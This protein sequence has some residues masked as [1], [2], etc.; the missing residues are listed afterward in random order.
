MG[1]TAWT[2]VPLDKN[3]PGKP[4]RVYGVP[5]RNT[6]NGGRNTG[7]QVPPGTGTQGDP[8]TGGPDGAP[9]SP[10]APP[11]GGRGPGDG[12]GFTNGTPSSQPPWVVQPPLQSGTPTDPP[13][14]VVQPPINSAPTDP[15]PW[16]IQP[17]PIVGGVQSLSATGSPRVTGTKPPT[18]SSP[19]PTTP[20][21]GGFAK[22]TDPMDPY[23]PP[24]E[25]IPETVPVDTPP[26][27]DDGGW[28]ADPSQRPPSAAPIPPSATPPIDPTQ[29]QKMEQVGHDGVWNGMNREQWRDAW[30]SQGTM[31]AQ[32]MDAWMASHGATKMG[33]NGTFLTPFGEVLDLGTGYKTGHPTAGWTPPG[34]GGGGGGTGAGGGDG[35][36]GAGTG[37]TSFQDQIRAMLLDQLKK[38]GQPVDL[39]DP[40]LKAE[41]DTQGNAL[42]Q[43]RRDRRG[44]AAERAAMQGL[45]SGGQSSGA[46]DSEVASGFE[47]KANNQSAVIANMYGREMQAKRTQMQNLLNMAVQSG[48]AESARALQLKIAEMDAELKRMGLAQSQSQWN[49]SFG[50]SAAQFEYLKN[51][52]LLGYGTGS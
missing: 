50:L 19:S 6:P 46:F 51:R 38:A 37:G 11:M 13:P 4:P 28:K 48:D 49:D 35:V 2:D 42:E 23:Q 21:S 32:A 7:S 39:N 20:G 43:T 34:G 17:D 52:D 5:G 8:L 9:R 41:L 15:P 25:G 1:T 14:W 10:I 30:M 33:D 18:A 3:Y 22:M 31:D 40:A 16:P 29:V 12:S 44:A 24:P 45:L 27:V 26:P 36:G 47:D